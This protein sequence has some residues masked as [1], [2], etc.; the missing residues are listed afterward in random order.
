L[1]FRYIFV[2]FGMTRTAYYIFVQFPPILQTGD[3]LLSLFFSI[4]CACIFSASKVTSPK[5]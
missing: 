1:C 5:L 2:S 4:I 3:Y